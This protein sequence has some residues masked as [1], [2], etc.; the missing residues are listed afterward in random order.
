MWISS[1]V[2]TLDAMR[3]QPRP[4]EEVLAGI[5]AFTCGERHGARLPVVL[6]SPDGPS[7]RYWHQWLEQLPGVVQVEVAFVSFDSPAEELPAEPCEGVS[8]CPVEQVAGG[9]RSK[10]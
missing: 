8:E 5:P 9:E 3:P 10:E 2:L 7:A 4:L 1:L 6:E